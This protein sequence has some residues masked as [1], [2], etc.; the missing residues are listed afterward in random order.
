MTTNPPPLPGPVEGAPYTTRSLTWLRMARAAAEA[1]DFAIGE[2]PAGP[3]PRAQ[4]TPG[5][6][7]EDALMFMARARDVLDAAVLIEREHGTSWDDIAETVTAVTGQP[8]DAA[9]AEARW[10]PLE[11]DWDDQLG[12]AA[13]PGRTSTIGIADELADPEGWVARLDEWVCRHRIPERSTHQLVSERMQRMDAFTE[14][15]HQ[16][17]RRDRLRAGNLAPLP[18]VLAPIYEREAILADA[19]AAAGHTSYAE[20]AQHCRDRAAELRARAGTAAADT[21][22]DTAERGKASPAPSATSAEA[23]ADGEPPEIDAAAIAAQL[24]GT[25]TEAEGAAY[26][27]SLRLNRDGLL[28]VATELQLVRLHSVRSLAEL[29]RRIIKQAIGARRKFE[30]LRQ[31]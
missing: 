20:H 22:T 17:T 30:G 19:M 13:A 21:D 7:L 1:A 6:Y 2:V 26:L 25:E 31:W 29:R 24:R 16:A 3:P 10:A 8:L 12:R 9:A 5:G 23:A 4:A 11:T 28:A 14:L 27:E 18:S 15:A